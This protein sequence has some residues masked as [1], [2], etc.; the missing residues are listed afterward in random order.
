MSSYFWTGTSTTGR[1][2]NVSAIWSKKKKVWQIKIYRLEI[3][4]IVVE[5]ISKFS[6]FC[7]AFQITPTNLKHNRMLF[8]R[9]CQESVLSSINKNLRIKIIDCGDSNSSDVHGNETG[10]ASFISIQ[11]FTTARSGESQNKVR[12]KLQNEFKKKKF[13]CK[14]NN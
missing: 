14:P 1:Y 3:Y 7:Q 6:C 2:L 13:T 8:W 10:N 11:I 5:F 9:I 4:F 12:N